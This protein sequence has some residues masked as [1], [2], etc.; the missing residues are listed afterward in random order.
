[1]QLSSAD[2]IMKAVIFNSTAFIQTEENGTDSYQGNVTEVGLIKYLTESSCP[3]KEQIKQ[4]D[5]DKPVFTIPFSSARKRATNVVTLDGGSKI[6]VFCKGAPEIVIEKCENY[7][8]QNGTVM[9]M[10]NDFKNHCTSKIQKDYADKCLRTLLV[11]HKDYTR[12]E[13]DALV[14]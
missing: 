9:R 7:I 2:D 11:A 10:N 6:R 1:M 3:T 8:G 4:R 12:Q 13:W 14:A 5:A